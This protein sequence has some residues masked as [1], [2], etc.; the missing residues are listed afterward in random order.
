MKKIVKNPKNLWENLQW[1]K[2]WN[3]LFA[4]RHSFIYSEKEEMRGGIIR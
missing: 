4:E 3:E 2:E 1:S